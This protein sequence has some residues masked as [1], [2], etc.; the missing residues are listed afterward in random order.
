MASLKGDDTAAP[1]A[2]CD[3]VTGVCRLPPRAEL[4]GDGATARRAPLPKTL[5]P[6]EVL[7]D[8][9]GNKLDPSAVFKGKV[10]RFWSPR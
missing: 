4:G 5:Q 8:E 10:P 7:E 6:L 1:G 3:P 9:Q 2:V